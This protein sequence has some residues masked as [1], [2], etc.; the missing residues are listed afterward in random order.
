LYTGPADKQRLH[1]LL[2]CDFGATSIQ[3][4]TGKV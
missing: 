4:K 3:P 1:I 2:L